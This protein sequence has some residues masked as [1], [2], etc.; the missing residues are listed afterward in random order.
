MCIDAMFPR[1]RPAGFTLVELV[2]FIVVVS[3][4]LLGILSVLNV[5]VRGSSD[6]LLAKQAL[7]IAESLLEEIQGK[8]FDNSTHDS[9]DFVPSSPPLVTERQNFD[10]VEDF[11][12]YGAQS[13]SPTVLRAGIYD[14]SGNAIALLTNY[15]VLVT[16]AHPEA[17][18]SGVAADKIWL[19]TVQV[20]DSGNQTYSLT[21][22]R[23]NYD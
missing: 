17:A 5:T 7:T 3:I 21:G 22:H 23:I 13:L 14:I 10:N 9:T 12:N 18:V 1:R 11:N 16:V 20:S 19:I 8:D 4:G 2:V 15:R 6:P